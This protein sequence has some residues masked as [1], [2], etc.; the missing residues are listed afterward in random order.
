VKQQRGTTLMPGRQLEAGKWRE[1]ELHKIA[2]ADDF[3]VAPFREDGATYGTPTWVWCVVVGDAVY[4]RAYHGHY[5]TWYQAALRQRAG[6]VTVAG[7]TKEVVFEPVPADD[8]IQD[9]IDGAYRAKYQGSPYLEAMVS[10]RAKS[11][12]VKVMPAKSPSKA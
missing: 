5:S 3:H 9:R 4:I 1:S 2:V 8:P 6:R 7:M 12:T 10:P 11:A